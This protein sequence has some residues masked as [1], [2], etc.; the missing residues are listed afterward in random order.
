MYYCNSYT[1]ENPLKCPSYLSINWL[2][3]DPIHNRVI[4]KFLI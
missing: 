3:A 1:I 4:L 2:I